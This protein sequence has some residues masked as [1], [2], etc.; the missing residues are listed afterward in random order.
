MAISLLSTSGQGAVIFKYTNS[1][2]NSKNSN[3]TL[4]WSIKNFNS[5]QYRNGQTSTTLKVL[6]SDLIQ[7]TTQILLQITDNINKMVYSLNYNHTKQSPPT[8]CTCKVTPFTGNYL[9]TPFMFNI[10]DCVSNSNSLSYKYYYVNKDSKKLSFSGAPIYTSTYGSSIVPISL[11]NV[12]TVDITDTDGL[13][14]TV[15]C[16][17]IVNKQANATGLS[18][19]KIADLVSNTTD[20]AEKLTVIKYLIFSKFQI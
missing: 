17:L 6:Q 3:F 5:I 9:E 18:A 14:E 8:K 1:D 10:N 11:N 13:S 2:K 4:L 16:P 19:S 20:S 12:Y 7:A 15:V